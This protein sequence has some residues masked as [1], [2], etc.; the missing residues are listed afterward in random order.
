MNWIL[1]AMLNGAILSVPVAVAVW[2]GL[3]LAPRR[4]LSAA[5]RYVVWWAALVAVGMLPL[6]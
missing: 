2:V 6:G 4:M 1:A 3:R 5:T